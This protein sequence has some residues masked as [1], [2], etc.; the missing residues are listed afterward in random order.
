V[1]HLIYR[2][3]EEAY[4]WPLGFGLLA[5]ALELVVAGTFAVR[6]P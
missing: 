2:R 1:E 3:Y 5:L 6:V 4:R